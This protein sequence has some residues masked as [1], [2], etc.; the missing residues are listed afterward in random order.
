MDVAGDLLTREMSE[1]IYNPF[2]L[3]LSLSLF[4]K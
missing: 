1:F 4:S 2:L 3:V